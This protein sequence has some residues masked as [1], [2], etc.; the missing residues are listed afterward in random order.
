MIVPPIRVAI[1]VRIDLLVLLI[2]L[3]PINTLP[4]VPQHAEL[5]IEKNRTENNIRV[6]SRAFLASNYRGRQKLPR[7]NL[8][9]DASKTILSPARKRERRLPSPLRTTSLIAKSWP[10][11]LK[12]G[13]YIF[14]RH[15]AQW[16]I[17]GNLHQTYPIQCEKFPNFT[18]KLPLSTTEHR[19]FTSPRT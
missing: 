1:L 2:Y 14:Y 5:H 9:L 18:R 3:L 10:S 19:Q 13:F 6:R 4:G 7:K 15:C 16:S 12:C 17:W 11:L 8:G